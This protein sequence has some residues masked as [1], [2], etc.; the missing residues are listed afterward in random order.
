[1]GQVLEIIQKYAVSVM[2]LDV[3]QVQTGIEGNLEILAFMRRIL[4]KKM[5]MW[6]LYLEN[7]LR[8]D[9]QYCYREQ[10]I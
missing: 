3:Q 1:M 8:Y 4:V 9:G 7:V 6:T 10:C 2:I 5:N